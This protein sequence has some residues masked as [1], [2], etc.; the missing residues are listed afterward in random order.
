MGKFL[1]LE[2]SPVRKTNMF[3]NSDLYRMKWRK[4]YSDALHAIV[5]EIRSFGEPENI[6]TTSYR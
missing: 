4:R 1:L 3:E 6:I 2:C 5:P